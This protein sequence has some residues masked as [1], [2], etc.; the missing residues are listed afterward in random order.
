[1]LGYNL[2]TWTVT[3]MVM[4]GHCE[5]GNLY[6]VYKRQETSFPVYS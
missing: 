6:L 5:Q 1:M 4:A 3:Q 2:H